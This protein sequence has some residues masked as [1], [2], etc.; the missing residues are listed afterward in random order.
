MGRL[1]TVSLSVLPT[2]S[3]KD[4]QVILDIIGWASS[5]ILLATLIRQVHKQWAEG[6][7]EGISKWLFIGQLTASTGFVVYSI[8]T[9]NIVFIVT[10]SFLALNSIL[11]IILYFYY[12]RRT[13][14]RRI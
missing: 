13:R 6:T 10:N 12:R 9:G 7:G 1:A 2:R 3:D 11:G 14:G 4:N 8:G 5:L